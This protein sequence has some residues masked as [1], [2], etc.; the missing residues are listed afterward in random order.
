MIVPEGFQ[1]HDFTGQ[2]RAVSGGGDEAE[3]ALGFPGGGVFFELAGR[4]FFGP[5]RCRWRQV[6]RRHF[7]K[8]NERFILWGT[9]NGLGA[10]LLGQKFGWALVRLALCAVFL[11]GVTGTRGGVPGCRRSFGPGLRVGFFD[12]AQIVAVI[13]LAQL[14]LDR[15]PFVGVGEMR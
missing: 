14:S 5:G 12:D 1:Q 9:F 3:L 7:G 8:R 2:G 4:G 13:A 10:F 11:L 15:L 6:D